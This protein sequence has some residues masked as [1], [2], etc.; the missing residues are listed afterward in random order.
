[1]DKLSRQEVDRGGFMEKEVEHK[2]LVANFSPQAPRL[3][4]LPVRHDTLWMI[5]HYLENNDNPTERVRATTRFKR[6]GMEWPGKWYEHTIKH[7]AEDEGNW[8]DE[9]EIS[10][11]EYAE[12]LSGSAAHGGTFGRQDLTR[13]PIIKHRLVFYYHDQKFELDRFH[14][15]F[16][17]TLLEAEVESLANPIDLPPWLDLIEVTGNKRFS[18]VR[19]AKKPHKTLREIKKL[20]TDRPEWSGPAW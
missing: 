11:V 13:Q 5:Q 2:Y 1:M 3:V 17:F 7:K 16:P 20:L 4:T 10:S 12:Y 8:E 6:F 18:G 15:P 9:R 19:L 14:H